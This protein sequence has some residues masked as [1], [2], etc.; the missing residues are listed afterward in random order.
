[1]DSTTRDP[2]TGRDRVPY[3]SRRRWLPGGGFWGLMWVAAIVCVSVA[4]AT[5]VERMTFSEVIRAAGVIVTS[6]VVAI[7]D[8]VWDAER[9]MP[10]TEVVFVVNRPLKGEISAGQELRLRFPGGTARNGL[11]LTVAGMPRFG[12][13]QRVVLFSARGIDDQTACPLVGWW[14]G[15]YRLHAGDDG[16]SV[17]NH[18]GRAVVGIDHVDGERVTRMADMGEAGPPA[19]T[20]EAFASAIR[21]ELRDR[22][23]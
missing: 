1:M 8:A 5:T 11:T 13:H 16:L 18:A 19:L 6:Q 9:G 20:L 23:R 15:L 17:T 3:P 22:A 4:Q 7:D 12:L 21:Q 10:Y 2:M 14:Q